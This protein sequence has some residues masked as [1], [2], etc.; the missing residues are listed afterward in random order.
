MLPVLPFNRFET[1]ND[2][3]MERDEDVFFLIHHTRSLLA[4]RH[5]TGLRR[6][7]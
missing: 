4:L 5:A 7:I 1:R 2:F 3:A 6:H